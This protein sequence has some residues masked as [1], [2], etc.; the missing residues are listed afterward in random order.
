[1]PEIVAV[2]TSTAWYV[3]Q[4]F[5]TQGIEG[6]VLRQIGAPAM[7]IIAMYLALKFVGRET[8]ANRKSLD[9]LTTAIENGMLNCPARKRTQGD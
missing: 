3:A 8:E 4:G 7:G 6:E 2:I 1:M 5:P 9:R